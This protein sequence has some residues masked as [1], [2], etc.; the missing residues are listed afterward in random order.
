MDCIELSNIIIL[1]PNSKV[2]DI[3][4]K[5]DSI[6]DKKMEVKGDNKTV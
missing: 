5:V 3:V 2:V 6:F 1:T 4:L